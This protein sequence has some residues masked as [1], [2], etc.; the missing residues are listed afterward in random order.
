MH[1]FTIPIYIELSTETVGTPYPIP[2]FDLR[3]LDQ[4]TT[5]ITSDLYT[6]TV[7]DYPQNRSSTGDNKVS[8]CDT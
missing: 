6:P 5:T 4:P 8:I 2:H 7:A 3:S 1:P